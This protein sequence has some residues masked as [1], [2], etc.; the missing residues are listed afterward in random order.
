VIILA[1]VLKLDP[2]L[3]GA[4]VVPEVELPRGRMPLRMRGFRAVFVE[5]GAVEADAGLS[6]QIT[7]PVK[8]WPTR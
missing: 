4:E 8:R 7:P 2:V 3:E 5:A 6:A 1:L